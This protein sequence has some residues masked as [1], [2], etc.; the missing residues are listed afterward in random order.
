MGCGLTESSAPAMRDRSHAKRDI[1]DAVPYGGE[2]V[3]NIF[4]SRGFALQTDG[5]RV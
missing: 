5:N 1:E 4:F 3:G 2:D